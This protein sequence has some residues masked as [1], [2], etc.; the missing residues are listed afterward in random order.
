[1]GRLT[2]RKFDGTGV[3]IEGATWEAFEKLARYE[4]AEEEGRWVALPPK[5]Q[6]VD[7]M[8]IFD[9]ITADGEGRAIILPCKVG[10]LVYYIDGGKSYKAK[11][12]A[13]RFNQSG[14]RIYCER[15][16]TGL[17]VFEGIYGK[18]VFLTSEA[19]KAALKGAKTDG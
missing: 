17:V 18:T 4:D 5:T 6:D 8:R 14:V 16:F 15:N 9:L 12:A 7:F 3:S 19:A 1:M 10:D 2:K 11:A 13:F